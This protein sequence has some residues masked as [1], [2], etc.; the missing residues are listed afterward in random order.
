MPTFYR[1][2]EQGTMAQKQVS[3]RNESLVSGL[4]CAILNWFNY[5]NVMIM[6]GS[7][8]QIQMLYHPEEDRILFR[9][10]STINQEFR[11]WITR[12]FSILLLKVLSDHAESDP[13]ISTQASPEAKQAVKSFKQQQAI[14]NAEFNKPFKEEQA[15]FPLGDHVKLAFRL[16]CNRAETVMKLGIHPKT[17]EG[18]TLQI[19]RNLN[20]SLTRILLSAI[21]KAGWNL[22]KNLTPPAEDQEQRIIN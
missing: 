8:S 4:S 13:D 9:V 22:S 14:N 2:S 19:D 21:Q 10:N 15:E 16:T 5:T 1:Q 6:S 17:G 3:E 18:I 12:R 11:F 7:I 20:T